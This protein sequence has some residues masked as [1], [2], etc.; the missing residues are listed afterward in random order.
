M[1]I[2]ILVSNAIALLY[3][4]AKKAAGQVAE[5]FLADFSDDAY[6]A[7]GRFLAWLKKKWSNNPKGQRAIEDLESD[8]EDEISRQAL[9]ARL[10]QAAEDDPDFRHE[11]E[12]Q[13]KASGAA[14]SIFISVKDMED[15]TGLKVGEFKSGAAEVR[16]V[17][18]K[19]K[20][21]TGAEIDVLGDS[22]AKDDDAR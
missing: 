10:A 11:L 2:D 1:G 9:K 15:I 12:Q 7:A 4:A 20:N 19:A 6:A 14:L 5:G 18:D 17:G 8:P 13:I 21:V 22:P 16:I 3:P